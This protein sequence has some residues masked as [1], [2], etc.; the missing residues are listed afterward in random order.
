[1]QLQLPESP[2]KRWGPRKKHAVIEALRLGKLNFG[3]A[4]RRYDLS[5]EE[6][7]QWLWAYRHREF[8]GLFIS[9]RVPW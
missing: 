6:L 1:M 4:Y 3:H 5:P 8:V 9:K 7:D 2:V